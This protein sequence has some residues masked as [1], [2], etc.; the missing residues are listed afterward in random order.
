MGR[1]ERLVMLNLVPLPS[2][3]LTAWVPLI[4]ENGV[5]PTLEKISWSP[6]LIAVLPTASTAV[7][8]VTTTAALTSDG[9]VTPA[10]SAPPDVAAAHAVL[11]GWPTTQIRI[12]RE[13][14]LLPI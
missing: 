2:A 12:G 9:S 1:S 7:F 4:S 8:V 5:G 3:G 10:M 11:P 13:T 6:V 14:C